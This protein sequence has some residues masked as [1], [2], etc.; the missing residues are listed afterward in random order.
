MLQNLQKN[1]SHKPTPAADGPA[2]WI[3]SHL[4]PSEFFIALQSSVFTELI[5]ATAAILIFVKKDA[6]FGTFKV[7]LVS[8]SAMALPLGFT[9]LSVSVA[10]F[11]FERLTILN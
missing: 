11:S 1:T 7:F 9:K 10:H 5:M 3:A 8:V 6:R 2:K 4:V